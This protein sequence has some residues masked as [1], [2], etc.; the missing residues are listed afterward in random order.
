MSRTSGQVADD[1]AA[2]QKR[3]RLEAARERQARDTRH[4]PQ[5][6]SPSIR[7]MLGYADP[8]RPRRWEYVATP[9]GLELVDVDDPWPY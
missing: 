7:R 1:A 5:D 4:R 9:G 3:E 2:R 6:S 8:P